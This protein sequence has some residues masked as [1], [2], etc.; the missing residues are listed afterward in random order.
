MIKALATRIPRLPEDDFTFLGYTVG[1]FYGKDGRA[2][3]GTRPSRK[4]IQNL[5]R[6]IH[7][8]TT[9]ELRGTT[10]QNTVAIISSLLR[11]WCGYF[12]QG[13]NMKTYG[14]IPA[15]IAVRSY[16]DF[17]TAKIRFA[18]PHNLQFSL[19]DVDPNALLLG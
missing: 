13:S 5:L 3:I 15:G 10:P 17:S 2:F 16:S 12:D 7:D 18:D 9:R 4:A 6:R 19:S 14:I 11:G 1:W 8:R